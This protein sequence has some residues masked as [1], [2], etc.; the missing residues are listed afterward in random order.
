[1]KTLQIIFC[2]LVAIGCLA[3]VWG[4]AEHEIVF[5]DTLAIVPDASSNMS[6]TSLPRRKSPLLAGL[7]S[8]WIPGMGQ[9]YNGDNRKGG[10][11]LGIEAGCILTMSAGYLLVYETESD[12]WG[13]TGICLALGGTIM[14]YGTAISAIIDAVKSA[15][16]INFENGYAMF[17]IGNDVSIGCR[18]TVSYEHPTYAL[19]LPNTLN[20]GLG[21]RITF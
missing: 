12:F 3:P 16:R 8:A 4:Q 21:F 11:Y 18:P 1:M 6:E 9:F 7:L 19:Q 13:W 10:N 2:F 5:N 17:D 15:K 20:A 14:Y